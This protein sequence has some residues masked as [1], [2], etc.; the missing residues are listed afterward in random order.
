MMCIRI[1]DLQIIFKTTTGVK[2]PLKILSYIEKKDQNLSESLDDITKKCLQTV[3]NGIW[4]DH[5]LVG[6][7][8][9]QPLSV[10]D[11]NLSRDC[12]KTKTTFGEGALKRI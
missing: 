1:N 2:K 8:A 6:V 4:R 3:Y 10:V 5:T 7:E 9:D 11:K 12:Q